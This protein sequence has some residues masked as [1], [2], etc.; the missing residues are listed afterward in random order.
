MTHFFII[1]WGPSELECPFRGRAGNVTLH[2][3]T[4]RQLSRAA[5][6]W[7]GSAV[8]KSRRQVAAVTAPA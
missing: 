4:A 2:G 6:I 7:S 8:V 3:F 1:A 5:E